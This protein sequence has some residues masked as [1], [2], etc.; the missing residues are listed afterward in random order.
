MNEAIK[1]HMLFLGADVCGIANRNR[2]MSAPEGY[3]PLDLF[4]ACKSVIVLGKAIPKGL[5]QVDS[6]LLYGH[7]NALICSAVDSIA[8]QGA[9]WLER[10][11]HAIAVPVPC[12]S[13]YEYWDQ[14]TQTGR[15]LLSMKHAAV[16]AGLGQLGKNSLLIHPQYG[17]LLTIGA[18][19][20]DLNLPSDAECA[21]LCIKGCSLCMDACPV[22]AIE[23]GT[24]NQ[25]RC[26]THT[27]GKTA[28]GFDTVDCNRC[29]VVCPLKYG[30][31]GASSAK[32]P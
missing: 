1:Q 8:L 22:Q 25:T 11:L 7:F 29:R 27:Y 32:A 16:L 3:S 24:V 31:I 14:E 2:F 18:I 6:R 10:Q 5:T 19:L 15:G 26:R 4:P 9:V 21:C 12:D 23:N 13:P 30:V 20:T 17:N 28:R